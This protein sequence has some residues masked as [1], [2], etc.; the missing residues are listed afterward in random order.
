MDIKFKY[1][2]IYETSLN[3]CRQCKYK[4]ELLPSEKIKS[5]TKA[6]SLYWE[7]HSFDIMAVLKTVTGL[8]FKEKTITCYLNSSKSF[9]EPLTLKIEDDILV[10]KDCLVHELIHVLL[11]ANN[12]TDTAGWKS[13]WNSYPDELK[14][15]K[16]HIAVHAIH[17]LF[18]ERLCPDRIPAIKSYSKRDPYVR[19]WEIVNEVGAEAVVKSVLG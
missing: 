14:L 3:T 2:D 10:L 11:T 8:S 9:S 6:I 12:V 15:T 18:A 16:V 4:A 13:M 5:A 19:S 7:R 17:L 1:S